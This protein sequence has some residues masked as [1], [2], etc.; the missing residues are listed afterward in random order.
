[1]LEI[2]LTFKRTPFFQL[3]APRHF[4]RNHTKYALDLTGDLRRDP[5]R[6]DKTMGSRACRDTCPV[7]SCFG[8]F[9]WRGFRRCAEPLTNFPSSLNPQGGVL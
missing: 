7:R 5:Y 4:Q 3:A 1:M 9:V 8:R 6:R 2:Y